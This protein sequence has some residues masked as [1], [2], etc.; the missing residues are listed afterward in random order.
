MLGDIFSDLPPVDNFELHDRQRYAGPPERLTQASW[1]APGGIA[2]WVQGAQ[3]C[4][5]GMCRL[6]CSQLFA[7]PRVLNMHTHD[8]SIA[9]LA[10]AQAAPLDDAAG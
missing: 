2:G 5:T 1:L 6:C 10:A 4:S 7:L 9:G 8:V 3:A